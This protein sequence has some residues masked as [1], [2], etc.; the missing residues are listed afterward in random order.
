MDDGLQHHTLHRDLSLLVLDALQPLGNGRVLPAGPLRE[1]FAC[2]LGRSDA[3]CAVAPY[4]D[5]TGARVAALPSEAALR[6]VLGLPPQQHVETARLERHGSHSSPLPAPPGAGT[7]GSGFAL[8]GAPHSGGAAVPRRGRREAA[9]R[10]PVSASVADSVAFGSRP[11]MALTLTLALALAL[12]LTLTLTLTLTL[13]RP[14]M[15]LLRAVMR[16]VDH[17]AARL[18]G[19]RVLAFTGTARPHRFFDT[20][21]ALG[22]ELPEVCALPDHAPLP[23][24]LLERLRRSAEAH[25]ALLATTAKDAARLSPAERDGLGLHVLPMELHWLPEAEERLDR[26]L[27]P[28]LAACSGPQACTKAKE[29]GQACTA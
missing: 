5:V 16:P 29:H 17:A 11:H 26:L 21:R 24:P 15:P 6:D 3:V 19:R 8:G 10:A 22:C 14:H 18:A 13:I 9:A 28:L 1:P 4:A 2:T 23:P 25:G 27:A 12:A 7:D 20:L